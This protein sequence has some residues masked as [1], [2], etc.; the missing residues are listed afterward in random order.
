MDNYVLVHHGIKNQRWGFRRYQN[1]DGSLTPAGRA[2][3]AKKEEKLNAKK[4]VIKRKQATEASKEELRNLKRDLK[5]QKLA[6]KE[7]RLRDKAE[8]RERKEN[9]KA[10]ESES[11]SIKDLKRKDISKMSTEELNTLV[12]RLALEKRYSDLTPEQKSLGKKFMDGV[13]ESA[14]GAGK[15]LLKDYIT[16]KGKGL[17]GLKKEDSLKELD[18]VVK[19]L[20]LEKRLNEHKTET[21]KTPDELKK[22]QDELKMLVTK[23]QLEKYKAKKK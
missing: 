4:E 6:A 19:K 2:R 10:L 12:N 3:Y 8:A 20:D 15:Q 22:L 5:N 21:Y 13:M 18:D 9:I 11:K 23:E 16:D 1:P 7:E 17:L 14:G